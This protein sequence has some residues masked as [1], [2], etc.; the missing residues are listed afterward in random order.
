MDAERVVDRMLECTA[1]QIVACNVVAGVEK[2]LI[3]RSFARDAIVWLARLAAF[4]PEYRA[5]T[6]GTRQGAADT[7]RR[8]LPA[9]HAPFRAS[10]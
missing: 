8:R 9:K 7:S 6:T 1:G 4:K 2:R 5:S 3:D 10:A